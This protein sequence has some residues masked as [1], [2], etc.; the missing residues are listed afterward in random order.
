[1]EYPVRRAVPADASTDVGTTNAGPRNAGTTEPVPDSSSSVA[2]ERTFR[3]VRDEANSA[4]A[5]ELMVRTNCGSCVRVRD[6]IAPI[7]AAAG[8]SFVVR[9]VDDDAELAME[10][11]DRVPVVV[12]DDEE[13]WCCEVDNEELQQALAE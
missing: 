2:E 1:M 10:F 13:F 5:V 4:H 7:V 12:L 3:Q 8:A 11:G 9:N 6:Q